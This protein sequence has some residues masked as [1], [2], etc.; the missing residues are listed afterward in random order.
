[1]PMGNEEFWVEGDFTKEAMGGMIAVIRKGY[2]NMTRQDLGKAIKISA[3]AIDDSEKGI[4]T[5]AP[6][7]LK[8]IADKYDL[9]V[10]I[11]ITTNP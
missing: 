2:L 6:A 7:I 11:L 5:K 9:K 8:K 1:M 3:K 4:G 10:E